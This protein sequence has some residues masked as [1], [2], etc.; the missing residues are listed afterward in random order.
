MNM[1]C[2]IN[3][4]A[5]CLLAMSAGGTNINST[6]PNL[7]P[8]DLSSCHSNK[9]ASSCIETIDESNR[10]NIKLKL[11]N[12]D[13]LNPCDN[14]IDE[15]KLLWIKNEQDLEIDECAISV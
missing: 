8:L 7:K 13:N 3:F 10:F 14:R 6:L 11:D 5:H 4:A 12:D 1:D 15:N 9:S 2:D